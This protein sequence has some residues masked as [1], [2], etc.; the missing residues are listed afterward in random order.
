[1]DAGTDRPTRKRLM[2][3]T[4]VVLVLI[5]VAGS[6]YVGFVHL[7]R[8][9][10]RSQ[11]INTQIVPRTLIAHAGGITNGLV[12]TN[13]REALDASYARGFRFT[14]VDLN[15]TTDGQIVAVHDWDHSM[16]RH[17][18][19]TPGPRTAGEFSSLRMKHGL[20]SL[21]LNDIIDWLREHDD[22]YIITDVKNVDRNVEALRIIA[23]RAPDVVRS[24]I[25]QIYRWHQYCDVRRLGFDHIIF[26]LYQTDL[27]DDGV[28]DFAA[29]YPLLAVTMPLDRSVASDLPA[30]LHRLGVFVYVHTVNDA[31]RWARLRGAG[32]SGIYTDKLEPSA[33]PARRKTNN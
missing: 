13:S 33:I 16:T 6:F 22:A 19:T 2:R 5:V 12:G 15:F 11:T 8:R 30:R 32:V 4:S 1:M 25:P 24:F 18:G 27:D 26:T 23:D 14:E 31:D 7:H 29:Q 17:F 3:Y 9:S 21:T 20:K 28:I 10:C